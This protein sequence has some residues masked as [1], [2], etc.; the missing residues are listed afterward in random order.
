MAAVAQ[1]IQNLGDTE[2][3]R[4]LRHGVIGA[5]A[6]LVVAITL[7]SADVPWAVRLLLFVPFFWSSNMVAMGLTGS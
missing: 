3:D 5:T 4:R 2:R 7:L 6:A 1:T